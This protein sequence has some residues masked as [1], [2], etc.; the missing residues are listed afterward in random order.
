MKFVILSMY[1]PPETGA[2]QVRLSEF[3]KQLIVLGNSVEVITAMPNYPQGK[4]FE[5]YR[6]RLYSLTLED[7]I[8]V[9]RVWL[10]AAMG[11]GFKR[12]LNYLS[13]TI[14]SLMGLF[15]ISDADYIII[16]SP[17]P[18]VMVSAWISK[19]WNRARLILI[20]SDL[21]PD[22]IR[23]MG[24][25]SDGLM[26]STAF[27]MEK[28][29]YKISY[30]VTAVT[31]GIKERLIH[32][33]GLNNEKVLYLP[34]GVD[35]DLFY[36]REPEAKLTDE[37]GLNGKM[38]IVYAG[39]LGIAQGLETAI[40]AMQILSDRKDICLV[41]I[42][43]GS[44]KEKLMQL[45]NRNKM[46]NVLFLPPAPPQ[47]IARL[48][49][50]AFAGLAL[51]KRI[52]L[53]EGARPS[54]ILPI[55]GSGRAVIYSGEGETPRLLETA[56]AGVSVSP[57]NPEELAKAIL[58]LADNNDIAVNLGRNGRE[59]VEKH[60]KWSNLVSSWLEELRKTT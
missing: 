17:P 51:L 16:E 60:Y 15:R 8:K 26:L 11:S 34:N 45:V 46:K 10:Y 54:K 44:E 57:E 9:H 31:E 59:F 53:F 47:Y 27:Q 20:V 35:T 22:S 40:N 36:P 41:L 28:W 6:G 42:G 50:I 55:M 52:K 4:I 2:P 49:S 37:L 5:A 32:N 18:T 30:R 33:K 38:I 7:G 29:V 12:I 19:M 24:L 3:A 1:W 23:D 56:N 25:M 48:Y 43:A 39:N 14:T 58:W 13:F 21:W